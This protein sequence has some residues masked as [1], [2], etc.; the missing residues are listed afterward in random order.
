MD[1]FQ[2]VN[3]TFEQVQTLT[4]GLHSLADTDGV[5]PRE[6]ALIREFY[7][8]CRP[9]GDKSYEDTIKTPF[10]LDEALTTLGSP[11]LRRLFIKTSWLLAFADGK[12]TAPERTRI[13]EYAKALNV[14]DADSTELQAQVKEYLLAQLT[15]IRNTAAVAEV[16]KAMKV[17]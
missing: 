13:A 5:H 14:S 8:A 12:V 7:D 17:I 11:E 4:R 2:N 10:A 1:F 3:L 6:E 15:H 16:A 9:A